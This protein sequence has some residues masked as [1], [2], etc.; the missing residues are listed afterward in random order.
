MIYVT[1]DYHGG[2][3]RAKLDAGLFA[4][5][6]TLTRDDCVIICGDFGMPWTGS[7]DETGQLDWLNAQPWTTLFVDG[8]HE[9]FSYYFEQ[10]EE[11]WHGGRVHRFESWPNIVHLMRGQVFELEGSRVFTMG[12][13]TSMDRAMRIEGLSWFGEE[14]PD[15]QE[16]DEARH[17]LDRVGWNV[18]YVLTHTCAN[19]H[20][21][22]ALYPDPNWQC[23]QTDAL[24][25]FFEDLEERL[26][27]RRWYFGH[28]HRDRD[29]DDTHTV[30]Y[31][32]VVELG[33]QAN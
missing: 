8:N 28:F 15:A 17:N 25:D 2:I 33:G 9:C 18:D 20:L 13:A 22:R 12:G 29:V 5:G 16:Y 30:L 6:R 7:N 4:A 32:R 24:T 26:T 23:V 19:R 21:K 10:P 14:L 31:R 3:E 1:G 11:T 27:Y